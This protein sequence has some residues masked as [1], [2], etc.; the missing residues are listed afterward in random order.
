MVISRRQHAAL[1][2]RLDETLDTPVRVALAMCY[3][4]PSIGAGLAELRDAGATR[5]LVLPLY[6]QY[7]GDIECRDF[8]CRDRRTA[9]LARRAG[10]ALYQ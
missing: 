10:T 3:G 9:W 5:V 6:P 7:S 4:N 1:Q 8:R 2:Q